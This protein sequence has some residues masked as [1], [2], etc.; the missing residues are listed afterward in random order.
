M[1]TNGVTLTLTH[2]DFGNR[3]NDRTLRSLM[4]INMA[5]PMALRETRCLLVH[6]HC[7]RGALFFSLSIMGQMVGHRCTSL[8]VSNLLLSLNTHTRHKVA[9]MFLISDNSWPCLLSVYVHNSKI[10]SLAL[11]INVLV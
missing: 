11:L 6:C 7:D 1:L 3:T 4:W 5:A 8:Y 10:S 2:A 9:N